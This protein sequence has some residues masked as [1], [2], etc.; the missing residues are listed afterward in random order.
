[1]YNVA[2]SPLEEVIVKTTFPFKDKLDLFLQKIE[3]QISA[4]PP[5]IGLPTD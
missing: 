2:I 1:M 3:S 5:N 4:P